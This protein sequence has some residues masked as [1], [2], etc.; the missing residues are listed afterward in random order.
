MFSRS[1]PPYSLNVQHVVVERREV[2]DRGARGRGAEVRHFVRDGPVR[3][4]ADGRNHGAG[5]GVDRIGHRF[6]VE[7][8]E[9]L[10]GPA[11]P[12][13][14]DPM[15]LQ[16]AAAVEFAQHAN[17]RGNLLPGSLR[18]ARGTG[19]DHFAE[20]PPGCKL[21]KHVVDGGA[22]RT[23][24]DRHAFRIALER[25]ALPFEVPLGTEPVFEL[26]QGQ[27]GAPSPLGSSAST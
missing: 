16:F 17:A 19:H 3:F 18:P 10:G 2:A 25:P 12:A 4:M 20:G 24:H 1:R 21:P 22:L 5:T 14:D 26:P 13:D 6:L 15:E 27:F 23:R 8:H 9:V 11:A 7:G